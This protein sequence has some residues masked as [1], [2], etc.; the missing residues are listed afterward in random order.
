MGYL[1][2]TLFG[3]VIASGVINFLLFKNKQKLKEENNELTD[4]ISKNNAK[5]IAEEAVLN[6]HVNSLT[7]YINR[8][9]KL[10][11][12]KTKVLEDIVYDDKKTDSE[13]DIAVSNLLKSLS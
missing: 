10:D 8:S 4:T 13:K 5:H 12:E 2:S 3:L 7:E 9:A 1:I 6:R 11:S